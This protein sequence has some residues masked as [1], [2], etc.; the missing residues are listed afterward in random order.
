MG[1]DKIEI[2]SNGILKS[3]TWTPHPKLNIVMAGNGGGKT[4]LLRNIYESYHGKKKQDGTNIIIHSMLASIQHFK[5]WEEIDKYINTSALRPP[6][7]REFNNEYKTLLRLTDNISLIKEC[8]AFLKSLGLKIELSEHHAESGW[9]LFRNPNHTSKKTIGM[10]K[11]APGEKTAFILWLLIKSERMPDILLLD[12]FDAHLSGY[13]RAFI[14]GEPIQIRKML[15][16]VL[17]ENFVKKGVQV[18]YATNN[19]PPDLST[20]RD[21]NGKSMYTVW[22]IN[23]G[24]IT[25]SKNHNNA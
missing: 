5:T 25:Q 4:T 23:D 2:Q 16:I 24:K 12:E 10:E 13:N 20:Y 1:I 17:I 7:A 15:Y 8:N 14:E 22:A 11:I 18:F 3:D 19:E 9:L 6:A 21:S